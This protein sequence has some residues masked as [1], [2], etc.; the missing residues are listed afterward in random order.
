MLEIFILLKFIFY[1]IQSIKI[2]RCYFISN[3]IQNHNKIN[4]AILGLRKIHEWAYPHEYNRIE[5]MCC[6]S[7]TRFPI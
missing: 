2:N 7:A 5:K 6:M 3:L 1:L 4:L